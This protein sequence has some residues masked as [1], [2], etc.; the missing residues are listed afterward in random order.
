[1][2][3]YSKAIAALLAAISTWGLTAAVDNSITLV[4]YFGLLGAVAAAVTVYATPNSPPDDSED[5]E[6]P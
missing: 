5:D 2:T 3:R 1:M 6:L 4:E